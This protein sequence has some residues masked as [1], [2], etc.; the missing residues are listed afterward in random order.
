M[1]THIVCAAVLWSQVVYCCVGTMSHSSCK[2]TEPGSQ[3]ATGITTT[4]AHST[5]C[6]T[7]LCTY[8]CSR[9]LLVKPCYFLH[10]QHEHFEVWSV[11][12]F[13]VNRLKIGTHTH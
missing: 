1:S 8:H 7:Q 13:D 3:P 4:A 11:S 5:N 2:Q 10:E 12:K 9:L 6:P